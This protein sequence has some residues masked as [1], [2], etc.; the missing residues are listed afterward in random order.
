M[1]LTSPSIAASIISSISWMRAKTPSTIALN[2]LVSLIAIIFIGILLAAGT[3]LRHYMVSWIGERVSSDIRTDV[4][5]HVVEMHPNFFETNSP[6]E[7]Q[8]RIVTDTTLLQS[9]IGSSA[10]IALRNI[11]MF[12]GGII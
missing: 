6:G 1:A 2:N 3:Y 7:I 9:V 10:S 12:I 8:S 5:A 11:L 4:F